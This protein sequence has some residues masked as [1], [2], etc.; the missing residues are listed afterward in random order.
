MK[1]FD[2]GGK[3]TIEFDDTQNIS[4][5]KHIA[6]KLESQNKPSDFEAV[7]SHI[8]IWLNRVLFLKLIEANLL[9]FNDFNKDLRFLSSTKI[10]SFKHLSHLFFEV[11]AKDYEA[12]KQ[13]GR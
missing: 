9:H 11:L 2:K 6:S 12:R 3:I 13:G 7:M 1:E 4:F 10:T 5:A 8:L